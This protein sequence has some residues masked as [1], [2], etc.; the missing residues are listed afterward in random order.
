MEDGDVIH[1]IKINKE[2]L[3]RK[4]LLIVTPMYKG[5]CTGVYAAS[6]AKLS[7]A[8]QSWRI[9]FSYLYYTGEALIPRARNKMAVEFL[10]SEHTHLLF[11]DSDIGFEAG[12]ILVML[13]HDKGIIAA[14][15]PLKRMNWDVVRNARGYTNEEL[16]KLASSEFAVNYL[17]KDFNT[18][19]ACRVAAVGCGCML[20]SRNVFEEMAGYYNISH[21][22]MQGDPIWHGSGWSFFDCGKDDEGY[23]Q[24]EDYTFCNRY[25]KLGGTIWLC[26]WM[27]LI[28]VGQMNFVGNMKFAFVEGSKFNV[29]KVVHGK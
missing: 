29:S 5:E 6:L 10:N 7:C 20:I 18:N 25:R 16:M 22:P 13:A 3:Q 24:P 1:G 8:L 11:V 27:T 21:K 28:H 12:N 14:P 17:D 23:Y 4:S 26:P 19:E 2:E 15:Y 9:N